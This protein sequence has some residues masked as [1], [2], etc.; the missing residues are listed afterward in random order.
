MNRTTEVASDRSYPWS[1]TEPVPAAENQG[2]TPLAVVD[3]R[4]DGS[5]EVELEVTN[6]ESFRSFVLI[7]L[8]HAEVLGPPELRQDIIAWLSELVEAG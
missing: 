2:T 6:R 4:P 7:F 1:W 8:D 5:V 3:T